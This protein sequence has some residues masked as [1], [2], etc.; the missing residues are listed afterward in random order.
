[1]NKAKDILEEWGL[2]VSISENALRETGRFS[3][4]IEQRLADLQAAMDNPDVK[5]IFCS[6]G[7]YGAVHLL[8]RINFTSIKDNPKWLIGFSDITALHAAL[9]SHGVMSIHGPM[10]KHFSD[11]GAANLSVLYTKAAVS[12]KDLNYTIPVEYPFLNRLGKATGTLFGGNLSVYTSLLGSNYINIPRNGILFLED[13]GEEPYRIDR[14]IY[15]L[16][17]AGV[18]N[19]I[20]GLIIGQFTEY[21]EDNRMYGTLYDSILSAVKEFDFPVCF[22]FPVGHTRINLPI[23]MGGKATLTI[24]KDTVLLKQRY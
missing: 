11:E 8:D 12:G 23:V 19:K 6:R 13:I 21:E 5:L 24:K 16:K 15:Q 14:M 7:G 22:G 20:K 4:F 1:V 3:G 9:Q 17:I 10:A 2:I 18:F